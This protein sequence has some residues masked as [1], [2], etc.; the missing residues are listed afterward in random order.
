MTDFFSDVM[1]ALHLFNPGH[2][3]AVLTG[4]INYTPPAKVAKMAEDL[5]LLPLWYAEAADMVYVEKGGADAF[6]RS[7]PQALGPFAR[8]FDPDNV[9]AETY[10]ATPWGLSPQG[11]HAFKRIGDKSGIRLLIPPWKTDYESL[12]GRQSTIRCHQLLRDF[13]PEVVL[14]LPPEVFLSLGA[15]EEYLAN[16]ELPL[17]LKTPYSSSGRGICWLRNSKLTSSEKNRIRGAIGKQGFV[18]LEKGVDKVVDF[19]LE[20]YSDGKGNIRYEGISVFN[21]E[22]GGAYSGNKL[23]SQESLCHEIDSLA[24]ALRLNR[25]REAVAEVLKIVYGS[26]YAGYLGVDMMLYRTGQQI[27]VHPCVEVNMRFTMGLVALLLAERRIHPTVEGRYCVSFDK[28]PEAALKKHLALQAACPLEFREGRIAKGYLSLCPVT[29]E[30]NYRA[31][32]LV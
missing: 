2:E 19:A 21:T 32:L 9:P 3:T 18:S 16:A 30:T 10:T 25:I 20:F 11:L 24:G 17:V 5:A 8:I 31:Y 23:A 13:F 12:T 4:A 6:V 26:V 22:D 14:P 29:E 27:A 1:P 7:L 28:E 15:I